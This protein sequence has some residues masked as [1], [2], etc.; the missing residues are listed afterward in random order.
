MT[1]I[2][3]T[4]YADYYEGFRCKCGDCRYNCCARDWYIGVAEKEHDFLINV[5]CSE[6]LHE[7]LQSAFIIREGQPSHK[8]YTF[9]RDSEG[10]CV[11]R[12][13]DGWCMLHRECGEEALPSVCRT[14]PR[15]SKTCGDA[16]IAFCVNSCEGIIEH[17]MDM[18]KLELNQVKAKLM[19]RSENDESIARQLE[20]IMA[21][22]D[23]DIPFEE[24]ISSLCGEKSFEDKATLLKTTMYNLEEFNKA[25]CEVEPFSGVAFERY[26][27]DNA[28]VNFREDAAAFEI[29]YPEWRLYFENILANH[30][31]VMN[32]P[33]VDSR[34]KAKD[35]KI[36]LKNVYALMRVLS[37]SY[38]RDK[39]G[40]V[41]LV[42]VITRIFRVIEHVSNYYYM[43]R[44]AEISTIFKMK[45]ESGNSAV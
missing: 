34:L 37:V 14:Y 27:G 24:R 40:I 13:A 15:R 3:T 32:Y 16:S 30:L 17:L 9:M 5:E 21:I 4:I 6:E 20:A 43:I 35:A 22:Q 19:E 25:Y 2:K 8:N 42:D 23:K 31:L 18:D 12:D 29:K 10:V 33:D 38:T 41:P 7:K 28:Y 11:L 44:K 1:Q 45:L 26:C 36:G 39:D